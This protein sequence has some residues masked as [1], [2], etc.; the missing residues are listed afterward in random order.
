MQSTRRLTP[1]EYIGQQAS[2]IAAHKRA[3]RWDEATQVSRTLHSFIRDSGP[4]GS[5]LDNG[6]EL[7]KAT[8]GRIVLDADYHPM[9]EDGVY[10]TWAYYS[11]IATSEFGGINVRVTGRDR[12]GH[13]KE[14][15]GDVYHHWLTTPIEI[16]N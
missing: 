1:A 13:T 4:S 10:K 9:D 8:P 6:T 15:L 7:V 5:G 14:Y 2:I 11:V 3:D 16:S 12:N